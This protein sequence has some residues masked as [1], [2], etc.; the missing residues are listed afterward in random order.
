MRLYHTTSEEAYESI[1]RVGLESGSSNGIFFGDSIESSLYVGYQFQRPVVL[2]IDIKDVLYSCGEV[3]R[4]RKGPHTAD[5]VAMPLDRQ[6][7]NGYDCV[8]SPDKI[9]LFMTADQVAEY[10][11]RAQL[12]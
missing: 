12:Y 3:I 7:G 4:P 9:K 8:I 11:E 2:E 1:K 5:I 10:N 6:Y